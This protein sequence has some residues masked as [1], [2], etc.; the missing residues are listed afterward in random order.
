MYPCWLCAP[1][2]LTIVVAFCLTLQFLHISLQWR[3]SRLD[4][5]SFATSPVS[6]RRENNFP[7]S[8]S[9]GPPNVAHNIAALQWQ[10]IISSFS[11][12][13]SV[14]SWY[15]SAVLG[16]SQFSP[17][18]QGCRESF[19]GRFRTLHFSLLDFMRF[20][21]AQ[22]LGLCGPSQ[23]KVSFVVSVSCHNF[24]SSTDMLAVHFCVIQV[25]VE[26]WVIRIAESIL[27]A[28]HL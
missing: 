25:L 22:S 18:M 14:T 8:A 4:S 9:H 7:R 24:A 10:C 2:P 19:H 1:W 11:L 16:L 5:V 17:S 26:D 28:H 6:R 15:F 3:G 21:L 27:G 23:L 13:S 20:L 12:T